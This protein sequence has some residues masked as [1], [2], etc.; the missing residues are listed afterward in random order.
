MHGSFS[1]LEA[2]NESLHVTDSLWTHLQSR[3]DYAILWAP[4]LYVFCRES[5]AGVTDFSIGR[6]HFVHLGTGWY[7]A[8]SVYYVSVLGPLSSV[9]RSLSRM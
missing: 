3:E 9:Y 1:K 4:V 6:L 8:G 2:S 5:G 7:F